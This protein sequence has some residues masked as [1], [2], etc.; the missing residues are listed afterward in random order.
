MD[1]SF[2]LLG[3]GALGNEGAVVRWIVVAQHHA[4]V[5][6]QTQQAL[7]RAIQRLGAPTREIATRR[8]LVKS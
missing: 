3:N 6:W 5:R 1:V 4:Y 8:V 2:T 7:D